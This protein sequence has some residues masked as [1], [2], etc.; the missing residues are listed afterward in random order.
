MR[1]P[2]AAAAQRLVELGRLALFVLPAYTHRN[3]SGV[4]WTADNVVLAD[5]LPRS[6]NVSTW[7]L[8]VGGQLGSDRPRASSP[9]IGGA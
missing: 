2:S 6:L 5:G 9:R 4:E 3:I 7:T 1:L 8:S